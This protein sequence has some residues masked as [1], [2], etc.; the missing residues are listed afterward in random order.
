[1]TVLFITRF[2]SRPMHLFG[3]VGTLSFLV[4]GGV[5]I[6]L[7]IQKLSAIS[8]GTPFRDVT[9][10]PLFYLALVAIIIGVQLF[11]AGFLGELISRNNPDRGRY[12]LSDE[13]K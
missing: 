12:D 13:I 7:I 4:G 2:G 8:K 1:M 9:D 6:W 11:I 3:T 5:A 10:Q